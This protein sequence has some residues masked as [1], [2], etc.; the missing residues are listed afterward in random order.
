LRSLQL[1]GFMSLIRENISTSQ[2]LLRVNNIKYIKEMVYRCIK[3]W[4]KVRILQFDKLHFLLSKQIYSRQIEN[5][6]I[7]KYFNE[8]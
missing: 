6:K 4:F 2:C 1:V 3:F 7:L 8:C 5:V